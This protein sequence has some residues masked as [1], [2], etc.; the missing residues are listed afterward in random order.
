[1]SA[2][3]TPIHIG[4]VGVANLRFFAPPAGTQ[5]FPW[6]AVD[7]LHACLALPRDLRRELKSKLRH[8]KWKDDTRT[9]ATAEG[10]VNLV[11]HFMAQGLI[12]SVHDVGHTTE[13]ARHQYDREGTQAFKLLTKGL[14]AAEALA[15]MQVAWEATGASA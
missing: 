13:G 12:D 15:Y 2:L 7:D 10:I 4:G 11:P 14:S 5:Q 6:V 1:M 8:T 9:V 3:A